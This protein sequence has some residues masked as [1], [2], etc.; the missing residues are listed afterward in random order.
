MLIAIFAVLV[1][2]STLFVYIYQSNLM[3]QQQKMSVWPYI[4][5]ETSWGYD[6]LTLGLTNKGIGPALITSVSIRDG[7]TELDGI[8]AL[9]DLVPDTLKAPF[10]FSSIY[11]GQVLMA[12]E[13]LQ[14]FHITEPRTV[15]FILDLIRENRISMEICYESVYGDSWLVN[16]QF[17][18]ETDC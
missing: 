6:Y 4:S 8:Q 9:M 17:V 14:T 2:F 11:P 15:Q 7:E 12:G 5:F 16:G 13:N 3:K 18:E 10:N 1:S